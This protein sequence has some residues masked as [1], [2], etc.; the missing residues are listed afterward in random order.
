ML[1][2]AQG[3][4][5]HSLGGLIRVDKSGSAH[6]NVFDTVDA[7]KLFATEYAGSFATNP[8]D[9]YSV[10]VFDQRLGHWL[11]FTDEL[12][13]DMLKCSSM[14]NDLPPTSKN[15]VLARK[16]VFPYQSVKPSLVLFCSVRCLSKMSP[17]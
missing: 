3:H 8:F 12:I 16:Y 10:C 2:K 13:D 14:L 1:L 9:E 5:F 4:R 7:T 15:M 17:R 11:S 6:E